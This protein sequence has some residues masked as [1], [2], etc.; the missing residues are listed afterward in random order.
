MKPVAMSVPPDSDPR[1][2][3][4][5]HRVVDPA[6]RP[7]PAA[8]SR[9]TRRRAAPTGRRSSPGRSAGLLAGAQV[10]G[11][12]AEVGDPGARGEGE[13]RV[14]AGIGGRAVVDHHRRPGQQRA[15][16]EV[17][18]DPGGRGVPEEPVAGADV[19]VQAQLL[20]L[21]E[22]DP[23][24]A[25]HDPLR[26]PGGARRVDD[27]QRVVE[28]QR[29]EHRLLLVGDG[30]GPG[31]RAVGHL[32]REQPGDGDRRPHGGQRGPELGDDVPPVVAPC[33]RTGSRRR[34]PA[35]SAR[36][37]RTGR[38]PRGCRSRARR[39]TTP[40]RSTPRRGRRSPPRARWA[41]SR[42]P[43]RRAARRAGA[44]WRRTRRPGRAASPTR[45]RPARRPPATDDQ[46]GPVVAGV[47]EA[48]ARRS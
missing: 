33:R 8:A 15:G 24:V 45:S 5:R 40:R 34:R 12:G 18:H 11:A 44:G 42:P 6:G 39:T 29:L 1:K 14:E 16:G 21:L 19:E 4:G 46:R 48:P 35:P 28:R 43:G 10:A 3:V 17:P 31:Q 38:A 37:G 30:V 25:V 36:S 20:A 13:L 2:H 27:P 26:Q 22:H 7:T 9:S 23:A 41:G 47:P 32:G